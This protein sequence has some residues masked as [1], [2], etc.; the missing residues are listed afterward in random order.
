[1]S[2]FTLIS[3]MP[4]HR[5]CSPHDCGGCLPRRYVP[6][7][8]IDARNSSSG[9]ASDYEKYLQEQTDDAYSNLVGVME[10]DRFAELADKLEQFVTSGPDEKALENLGAQTIAE[11]SK[12]LVGRAYTKTRARGDAIQ[13]DSPARQLHKLRIELKRFRYLLDFFALVQLTR[14]QEAIIATAKLQDVL[15]EHQDAVTAIERLTVYV[16]SLPTTDESRDELLNTARRM[17]AEHARVTRCRQ[18]F[19]TAWA[20]F[21]NIES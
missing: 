16:G 3:S 19:D 7:L 14:W 4:P 11:C 6:L 12:Q 15:G 18:E 5:T 2:V 13:K 21:R 20:A 10:S 8:A 9:E 1:M 17:Q